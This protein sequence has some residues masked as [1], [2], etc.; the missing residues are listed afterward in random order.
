MIKVIQINIL[1]FQCLGLLHGL[2]LVRTVE[3]DTHAEAAEGLRSSA[4]GHHVRATATTIE[5][6][7]IVTYV[8]CS[9]L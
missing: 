9:I 3:I 1:L 7:A 4:R 6:A 2:G 8:L 5:G